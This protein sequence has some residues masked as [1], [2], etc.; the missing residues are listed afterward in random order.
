MDF[1]S[2]VIKTVAFLKLTWGKPSL[3]IYII[4][5]ILLCSTYCVLLRTF[6]SIFTT[7]IN[8]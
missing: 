8:L 2:N 7:G 5:C 6:A 4:F 1:F 3:A